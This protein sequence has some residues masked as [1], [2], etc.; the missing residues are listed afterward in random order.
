VR[1][2][3]A[4]ILVFF[5][6]GLSAEAS[7]MMTAAELQVGDAHF[8]RA[9]Q[10]GKVIYWSGPSGKVDNSRQPIRWPRPIK[11]GSGERLEI[12]VDEVSQPDSV[13]LSI[14]RDIRKN[15]IPRGRVAHS[16]CFTDPANPTA[17]QLSPDLTE[18]GS[19]GWGVTLENSGSHAELYIAA[20]LT[21]EAP[22]PSQGVWLF[23]ARLH[24]SD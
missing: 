19:P 23:H 12:T 7:P 24:E 8:P 21:W 4:V 17:C 15:G 18:D 6:F 14:W 1:V 20:N 10:A 22:T 5:A 3:A 13:E 9:A 11:I 16:Q 2:Y